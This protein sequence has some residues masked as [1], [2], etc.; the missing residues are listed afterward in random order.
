MKFLS[1]RAIVKL[2]IIRPNVGTEGKFLFIKI[3]A[4]VAIL[5]F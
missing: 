1:G 3:F 4:V 5:A 2:S